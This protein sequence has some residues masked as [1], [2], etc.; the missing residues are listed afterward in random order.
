[1]TLY[2]RAEQRKHDKLPDNISSIFQL[3]QDYIYTYF[4]K[5]DYTIEVNYNYGPYNQ[6]CL[7]TSV[8]LII[9]CLN[10]AKEQIINGKTY[11]MEVNGDSILLDGK[12]WCT[13]EQ[14]YRFDGTLFIE[15]K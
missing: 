12:Y 11:T 14:L 5:D 3:L 7:S 8:L 1:M 15:E 6:H 10:E 13:R 4:N 2:N 9:E